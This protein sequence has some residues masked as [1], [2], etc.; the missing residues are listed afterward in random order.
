MAGTSDEISKANA[1]N[2]MTYVIRG[3]DFGDDSYLYWS[4]DDGW[5]SR[6]SA[7]TFTDIE[8]MFFMLPIG[9]QVEWALVLP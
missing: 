1:A 3:F 7:T 5:G 6:E 4:N 8:R 9:D 2:A